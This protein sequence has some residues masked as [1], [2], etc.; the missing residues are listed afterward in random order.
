M[1]FDHPV[2]SSL[3]PVVLLIGV[4][5]LAGR[6][7]L[8]RP[9]SVRD[10]SNLVFLVLTQAL[11][12]RTMSAVHLERLDMRPVLQYFAV[13][14]LLFF[15]MCIAYGRDSRASVLALAG[16]FSNTLMIGVPLIGLAY[17]QAGQVL[18]FTLISLHALVLLTL[19]TVVLEFQMA[20]EQAE[21]TGRSRQMWRTLGQAI[22][23]AVLHPVPLPILVGLLYAQ[24]GWGLHP[25]VDKP[26]QLLG[27]AFGPI[28]LVLVGIT[29]SQ[30]PLGKNLASAVRLSL[31]KTVLHPVLMLALGWVLG[32]RGMALSVMVVVAAL[33]IGANVFLFSQRYRKEEETVTAAVAISTFVSMVG[34]SLAMALLPLLPA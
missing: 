30:T 11:L 28:A 22:R 17:G 8:M 7:R 3:L 2:L 18:L 4:G 31:V 24:T 15:A 5:F 25:V 20:R 16:I 1:S 21:A 14:A 27:S 32:L 29:L 9:E 12:F 26:L 23:S 6:A 34:I 10:L 33:P 13:A 19:A